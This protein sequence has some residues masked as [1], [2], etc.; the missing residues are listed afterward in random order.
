MVLQAGPIWHAMTKPFHH[1]YN[2]LKCK[3]E[4]LFL[5]HFVRLMK[6]WG[7]ENLK[8]ENYR[9]T[10]FMNKDAKKVKNNNKVKYRNIFKIY[11]YIYS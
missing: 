11:I 6:T 8:K 5:T 4:S 10:S 9:P 7:W 3:K 2:L 1:L